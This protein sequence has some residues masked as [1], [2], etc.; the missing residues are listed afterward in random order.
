M[1]SLLTVIKAILEAIAVQQE[2]IKALYREVEMDNQEA[3]LT[4]ADF[5]ALQGQ[6]ATL[7]ALPDTLG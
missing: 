1:K 6:I 5:A 4:E 3:E 7:I 2:Q